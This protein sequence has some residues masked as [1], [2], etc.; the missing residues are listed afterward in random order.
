MKAKASINISDS[1]TL[2][3]SLVIA[4]DRIEVQVQL[5][6]IDPPIGGAS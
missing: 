6:R 2:V 3:E 1:E 5:E 4:R